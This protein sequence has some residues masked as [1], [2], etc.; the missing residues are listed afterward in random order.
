MVLQYSLVRGHEA[1][2][3]L[4]DITGTFEDLLMKVYNDS[5]SLTSR[6]RYLSMT[7]FLVTVDPFLSS[8]RTLAPDRPTY[9]KV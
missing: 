7:V 9:W 3:Q 4:P 6:D 5:V 8:S 2:V 1:G